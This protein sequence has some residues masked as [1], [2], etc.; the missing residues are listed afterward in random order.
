MTASHFHKRNFIFKKEKK[1]KES[2]FIANRRKEKSFE[3]EPAMEDS[4]KFLN[5]WVLNFQKLGLELKCPLWF[6]FSC[7][8]FSVSCLVAEKNKKK[9]GL[10]LIFL[11]L[12]LQF[13]LGQSAG[14]FAMQ[15]CL[16]PVRFLAFFLNLE[17]NLFFFF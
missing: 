14:S 9:R 10:I 7:F 12:V 16:L 1:K 6:V 2:S 15:S 4:A 17:I 13:K 11:L 8:A 5:P 3:T